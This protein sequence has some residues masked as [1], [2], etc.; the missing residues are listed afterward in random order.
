MEAGG[1]GCSGGKLF[2]GAKKTGRR[3]RVSV[4]Q[5]PRN[6]TRKKSMLLR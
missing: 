4:R 3:A 1:C 2:G 5:R 6:L